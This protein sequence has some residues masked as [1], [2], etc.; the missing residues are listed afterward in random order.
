MRPSSK[1]TWAC[2]DGPRWLRRMRETRDARSDEERV[3]VERE[4]ASA[5]SESDGGRAAKANDGK[6]EQRA[7]HSDG[8]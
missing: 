2:R 3:Q 8:V 5:K 4:G 6:I 1:T 7:G